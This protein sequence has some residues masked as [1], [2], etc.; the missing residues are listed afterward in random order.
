MAPP[1]HKVPSTTR[2]GNDTEV[3]LETV[4][5]RTGLINARPGAAGSQ[6]GPAG[7]PGRAPVRCVSLVVTCGPAPGAE[8]DRRLEGQPSVQGPR[9]GHGDDPSQ[10]QTLCPVVPKHILLCQTLNPIWGAWWSPSLDHRRPWDA[11]GVHSGEA[12]AEGGQAPP[13]SCLPGLRGSLSPVGE[14]HL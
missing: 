2:T 8:H 11:T 14:G 6:R 13:C 9:E 7:L 5:A 1:L 3:G 10:V 12:R 4:E